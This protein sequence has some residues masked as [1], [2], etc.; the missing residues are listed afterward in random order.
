VSFDILIVDDNSP[1]GTASLV[2]E[3]IRKIDNKIYIINR[4][5]KVGLG[6]AYKEG[7]LWAL[8]KQYEYIFEM[9]ADFSHNPS[10]LI[11]MF[12]NLTDYD[13]VIGSRYVD[14]I[15]VVNW[16]LSRIILSY[17]ASIYSRI[18]TGMSVKDATSGFVGFKSEV[19]KT[20]D[21]NSLVFNG[22][23]FQIELKFK[24]YLNKFKILEIPIIFK[25]RVYGDSKMNSSIIFEAVFGLITM[26]LKSFFK[27]L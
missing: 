19:L 1:D 20:I 3:L 18:I 26:R 9:D 10:D 4:P 16:P 14:G 2:N 13:V 8:E 25:D 23:A 17:F 7:F 5:N 6:K 12:N 11:R 24:S 22:Y 15:N 21:L 27:R